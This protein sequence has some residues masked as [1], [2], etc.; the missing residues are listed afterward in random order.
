GL[1]VNRGSFFLCQYLNTGNFQMYAGFPVQI[2][3]AAL[4]ITLTI[5]LWEY[6]CFMRKTQYNAPMD[7][8]FGYGK[9]LTTAIIAVL[10]CGWLLTMI[11]SD[12]VDRNQK[13]DFGITAEAIA[14]GISMENLRKLNGN[15]ADLKT[16]DYRIIQKYLREFEGSVKE[17][18]WFYLTKFRG[19]KIYFILDSSPENKPDFS[20]PGTV[21]ADAPMDL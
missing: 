7:F 20:P 2:L 10:C 6:H 5:A 11:I 21:Y 16:A 1:V 12:S 4:V 19:G 3:R 9:W 17:I 15:L 13:E 8:R 14:A 18:R